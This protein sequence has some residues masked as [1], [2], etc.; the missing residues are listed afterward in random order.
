MSRPEP[1]A[2]T[3][4]HTANRSGAFSFQ[5]M[6]VVAPLWLPRRLA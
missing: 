1:V 3:P 2:A 6:G 5:R 4:Q